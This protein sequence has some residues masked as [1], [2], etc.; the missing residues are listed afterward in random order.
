[1]VKAKKAA[2]KKGKYFQIFSQATQPPKM[3]PV[4]AGRLG[5]YL[6][7]HGHGMVGVQP[8]LSAY[9]PEV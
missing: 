1:M 7:A 9:A 3:K 4:G 6:Q 8:A 2:P 5:C